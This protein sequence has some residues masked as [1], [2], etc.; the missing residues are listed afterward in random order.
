MRV[1]RHVLGRGDTRQ[2]HH[3]AERRRRLDTYLAGGYGTRPAG[4][5]ETVP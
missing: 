1:R 2:E 5:A 4:L 3:I